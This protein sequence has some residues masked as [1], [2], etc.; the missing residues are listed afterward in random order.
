LQQRY[1]KQ[2]ID[3]DALLA[4][5]ITQAMNH[6]RGK[7][8][9]ISDIDYHVL[10]R[11]Y[12]QYLR[13]ASLCE[14]NDLIS[15]AIAELPIF[16]YYSLDLMTLYSCV[17]GQKYETERPTAK[18]R[19]SRKYWGKGRGVVAYT[20]LANHIP[21]QGKIIGA[22]EH[23]SYF[24]FDIYQSN[25]T[26]IIPD[27]IS[28][29]MHSINK[30][31]FT[32][33]EWFKSKFTPRFTDIDRQLKH[34]YCGDDIAN[35]ENYLIN[36]AGQLDYQLMVEEWPNIKPI[37]VTLASREITQ[38]KII[39]KLCTYKQNRTR[40]AIFEFDKLYRSIYTLKYLLDP[41]MQKDVHRSQNRIE[42]YHQLRSAIAQVNGKK[43]L[44]GKTDI[45]V[46]I[47]NNCG[48]LIAN[49]IIYYNSA[50]LSRLLEK[51]L[52]EGN[53]RAIRKLKLISPVAWQHIHLLGHYVFCSNKHAIDLEALIAD[54]TIDW[55]SQTEISGIRA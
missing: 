18:A 48:R 53:H 50:L 5:I 14:A 51:Y 43:Q 6:S 42:S 52:R 15:N 16:P 25:T 46:E 54:L 44:A 33:L 12:K 4:V 49:A 41:K 23:E 28:G 20:L 30:A 21:L 29:D 40:K 47:S 27:A 55:K 2:G 10:D 7:M 11:V 17:D 26:D 13:S 1:V 8:A 45:E 31:N 39:K 9:E 3:E 19:H 32:I 24:V 38:S 34:L 35:Y 37:I 36:P 22:H